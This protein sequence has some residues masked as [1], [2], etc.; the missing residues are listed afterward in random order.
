[1]AKNEKNELATAATFDLVT[2]TGDIAEAIAE[3]MDG[4][5]TIPYDKVK[6]PSG[7]GA[8]FELP[9]EDEDNP[10]VVTEIVGVILDHHPVNSRWKEA[11]NGSEEK[12]LCSSYDGKK[13][14]EVETGAIIDCAECPYN[15]FGS[16]EDG[17]GKACKNSHRI[18][19]L[20]E[21]NPVP[22]VL[23]LPP[24]SIKYARDYFAKSIVLKGMR[25]YDAITKI[26]L[27]KERSADG[28]AYSRACFTFIDKL[29][30][31]QAML[32]KEMAETIKA[33]RAAI[34]RAENQEDTKCAAS[35]GFIEVPE[36]DNDE[37][38]PFN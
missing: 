33:N 2:L 24:T 1:M 27:K 7:G 18:Y 6:I 3:E 17:R 11:Y 19:V 31:G 15:E 37:G 23:T 26:T 4:L 34:D 32:T 22:L 35:D 16:A 10:D 38:L 8:A 9:T 25:S 30:A 28:I 29:T 20:R 12:P 21:S 5:G 13:G 14:V 36:G